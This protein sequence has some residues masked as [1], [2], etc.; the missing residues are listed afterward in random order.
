MHRPAASS[1]LVLKVRELLCDRR[2]DGAEQ[3]NKLHV[4]ILAWMTKRTVF[5]QETVVGHGVRQRTHNHSALSFV[6][7]DPVFVIIDMSLTSERKEAVLGSS[8][9]TRC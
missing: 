5:A 2:F 4:F 6:D 9:S 8:R 3:A 7:Y 1:S